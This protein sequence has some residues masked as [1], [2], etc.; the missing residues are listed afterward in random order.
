MSAG[1]AVRA[2]GHPVVAVLAKHGYSRIVE[3]EDMT[4][5]QQIGAAIGTAL[6]QVLGHV[7]VEVAADWLDGK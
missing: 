4:P 2:V 6:L 7:A 3:R 5:G 1:R